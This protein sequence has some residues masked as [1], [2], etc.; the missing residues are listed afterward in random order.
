MCLITSAGA[1]DSISSSISSVPRTNSDKMDE[2]KCD[3]V[4]CQ[5]PWDAAHSS[6]VV[7]KVTQ[8]SV[9][10]DTFKPEPLVPPS[11]ASTLEPSS[12]KLSD[13]P[14][15]PHE[16]TTTATLAAEVAPLSLS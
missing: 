13:V 16:E 6:V 3:L 4:R 1:T 12:V 8:H 11:I 10:L 9:I 14:E 7:A 2:F 5:A 15:T